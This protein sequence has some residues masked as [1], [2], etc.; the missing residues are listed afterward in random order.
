MDHV[1]A[2]G[3]CDN[4]GGMT[5]NDMLHAYADYLPAGISAYAYFDDEAILDVEEMAA[6][7]DKGRLLNVSVYGEMQRQ[8][9]HTGEGGVYGTHW[10][11][12]TRADRD[13]AGNLLGFDVLDS[14]SHQDYITTA[15]LREIYLGH[16]GTEILD[17]TCIEVYGWGYDLGD[18]E[19]AS[20]DWR[21][22][23]ASAAKN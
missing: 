10:L 3:E 7:I 15:Q 23:A 8:G 4:V 2:A 13:A 18:G 21:K 6:R 14:A 19:I 20:P 11:V 1:L 9:G 22:A 16:D 12:L 5:V 17:P